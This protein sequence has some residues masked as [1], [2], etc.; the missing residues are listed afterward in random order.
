MGARFPM[1][2]SRLSTFEQCPL[3]FY[4]LNVSKE[5]SDPG[6]E[7]TQYGTRVHEALEKYGRTRNEEWLT[8]ETRKFKPVVDRIIAQPGDKYYEYRMAIKADGTP[9]DWFS[10]EVWFRAVIDVLVRCGDVATIIDFKTGKVKPDLTQLRVFAYVV[11]KHMPSVRT[12]NV[13]YLWLQFD[14]VTSTTFTAEQAREGWKNIDQRC[15]EVD[16]AVEL[17]VFEPKP[18]P[19]CG[20]CPAK[21]ICPQAR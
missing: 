14:E 15:A 4:Y 1:S 2:Y 19:L 11:H 7:H 20:W 5:V 21:K 12:F 8:L 16:E 3:K 13:A 9:C 6:N 10:K 18:S 17:G